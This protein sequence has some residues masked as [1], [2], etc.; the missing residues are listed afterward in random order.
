MH[1]EPLVGIAAD[2]VLND[3]REQLRVGD[4]VGFAVGGAG[5]LHG[6]IEA[7]A[8]F[9]QARV[10]DGEAR[11]DG[12]V[13]LEGH[14]RD[15]AGGAGLDAE[16][17]YEH[18]LAG[19]HVGVHEDADGFAFAHG[20]DE[21][22]GEIF[23]HRPVAV[24]GAVLAGEAVEIGIIERAHDHAQR[25]SVERVRESG[26]LPRAEMRRQK[27]HALAA[28]Q[29]AI[30]VLESFIDNNLA[31][32]LAR[33]AAEEADFCGLAAKGGEDSMKDFVALATRLIRKGKL[34]IP[35]AHAAQ[36]WMKDVNRPRDQ[37]AEPSRQ[38]TRQKAD[39]LNQ[40]PGKGVFESIAQGAEREPCLG[41]SG[42]FADKA[43]GEYG[44]WLLALG[45]W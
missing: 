25:I 13:G 40:G 12:G 14:A 30:E 35:H 9:F 42:I 10:P 6:G 33:V 37:N 11:D 43:N 18:A 28:G 26:K 23:V 1:P 8:I 7:Q 45:Y 15:A 36:L 24:Q 27:Q 38:R 41:F 2:V 32:V 21:A 22:A 31:D 4:D 3:F 16:E 17:V 39:E 34:Q 19:D 20:G 44:S 5:Q 29:R